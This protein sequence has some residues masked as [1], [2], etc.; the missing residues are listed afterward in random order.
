MD[1]KTASVILD[2]DVWDL[3]RPLSYAVPE[4]LEKIVGVGSLVRVPLRGR[5]MRGWVIEVGEGPAPVENVQNIA[6]VSGP[7]PLL[8]HQLIEVARNLARRYV[9]PVSSFLRLFTPPQVGRGRKRFSQT[10]PEVRG[11]G[12]VTLRR[13]E[14]GGDP[15]PIYEDAI[16]SELSRGLGAIVAVPEVKEGSR[17]LEGLTKAFSDRAANVHSGIDP[18]ERSAAL[19]EVASGTRDVVLGGRG[20]VFAPAF[21]CGL[22]IIHQEH[23][24]SFKEQKRPYYDARVAALS[25]GEHTG[26]SV[27]LSSSTPS[28]TGIDIA[29]GSIQQP[30]HRLWPI[31]EA[32]R[33][34]RQG[35]PR[36]VI[37]AI[38]AGYK[39]G[40]RTMV[41]LPRAHPTAAGW[42]PAEVARYLARVVPG[43]RIGRAD[44]SSIG[45]A[46]GAL[47]AVLHSDVVVGTESELTEAERPQFSTAVALGV[48]S[49]IKRPYGRA[50]EDSFAILWMLAETISGAPKG[51]MFLE[52][53]NPGHYLVQSIIRGSFDH[54]AERELETRK[55]DDSP[56]FVH[57]IRIQI[58]S[59]A[60]HGA[61]IER[62]ERLPETTVM[63]PIPGRLGSEVLLKVRDLE[64]VLD[65]LREVVSSEHGI[66]VEVD[67][68]E[69]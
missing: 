39:R 40:E 24:D 2:L 12:G 66:L 68:R 54:F 10:V 60:P 56:P 63:G 67:P 61:L 20:A 7:G 34:E 65:P 42:G 55:A 6:A 13:L 31:V 36:P 28:L 48:D 16:R 3:D 26:A 46:P 50:L 58:A 15:F 27:W 43:A 45:D 41:L 22:I 14:P 8:D 59:P 21:A 38:I 35:L 37:A 23:D 17:V 47:V 5:R 4:H 32:V 29:H 49:W 25:R 1:R 62:L 11:N 52:T 9:H 64:E 69:W 57:L 33:P 19:W 53:A 44:R 51:R 18:S 30:R